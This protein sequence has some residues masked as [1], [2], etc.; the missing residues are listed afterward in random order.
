MK[1]TQ[2]YSSAHRGRTPPEVAEPAGAG[3]GLLRLG[4]LEALA[5]LLLR[6]WEPQPQLSTTRKYNNCQDQP[7]ISQ[8]LLQARRTK[9]LPLA[10]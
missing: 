7:F 3:Q 2:D 5:R 9:P 4:R 10:P 6:P 1:I 8:P